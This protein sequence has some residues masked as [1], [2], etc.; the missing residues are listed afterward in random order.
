MRIFIKALLITPLLMTVCYYT[1]GEILGF[2]GL[3]FVACTGALGLLQ[4]FRFLY[5]PRLGLVAGTRAALKMVDLPD[6]QRPPLA[7]DRMPRRH[8]VS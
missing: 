4:V 7:R 1:R 3:L 8:R 6:S 5:F 2:L